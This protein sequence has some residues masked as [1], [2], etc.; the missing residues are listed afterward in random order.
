MTVDVGENNY[1]LI[2]AT[3]TAMDQTY[4]PVQTIKK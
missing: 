3:W 2:R 1:E 4:G